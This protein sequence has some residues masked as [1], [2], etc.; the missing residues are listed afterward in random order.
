LASVAALALLTTL[1]PAR[2]AIA[3]D[4][5]YD[6]AGMDTYQVGSA[7]AATQIAYS[8][9][10]QLAIAPDGAGTKFSA[11]VRYTRTD[12]SGKASV[13][14]NFVQVLTSSGA[15]EDRTDNDPD[16]LTV[17]NQP[18]AVQLDPTTMQDLRTM[19]GQ[20]PFQASSPVG[21][22]TLHGFLQ[23]AGS[24]GKVNGKPVIGVRFEA[25]GPM[26]GSLPDRSDTAITGSI[27]MDGTAYYATDT[28]LLFALDATLTIDGQLLDHQKQ[29][30]V[31]IVYRRTIRANGAADAWS[32]AQR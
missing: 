16:F 25:D 4:Q 22:S 18:F 28:A 29:V 19:Q 20:I 11:E 5:R 23:P 32:Q 9:T 13:Q 2:A 27:R 12:E 14:A 8:G 7:V 31:H 30:P 1:S 6:V 26:T 17:L 21:D 3:A 10:Q 24:G 15:F